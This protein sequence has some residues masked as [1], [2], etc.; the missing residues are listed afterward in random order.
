MSRP[1]GKR[2]GLT[3]ITPQDAAFINVALQSDSPVT[4]KQALQH[5]CSLYRQGGRL[6]APRNMK[7][8]IIN[9]LV[10]RDEKVKRWAFNA[11]AQLGDEADVDLIIGPWK[12]NQS[13]RAVF[14]AGLTALSTLLPKEQLLTVLK[15][16]G[17][18]LDAS[19]LMALGQQSDQFRAELAQVRLDVDSADDDEL[20]AATLLIGLKKAPQ[21]L[22]S[23]R[24]PVSDVIGDLNTHDDPTV[25][26]YSFWATVEHPDLGFDSVRVPPHA[27]PQLP[28][29]VQSWAYRTLTKSGAQAVTH[30]EAIIIGS[31]S[32][33]AEV[34]EGVAIGLRH[35]YYDS[36]DQTVYDW[37]LEE[38]QPAV[39]HRLLEHMAGHSAKSPAYYEEVIKAFRAEAPGSVL[40]SRLEAAN[41]DPLMSLEMRKITLQMCD[42]DLFAS[43]VGNTMNTQNF[44]GPVTAAGI[45]NSGPGNTGAVQIMTTNEARAKVM[46]VLQELQQGLEATDAPLA[47]AVGAA[48]TKDAIEAPTKGKLATLVG[49]L[50][51]I[52]DG[53]EAASKIGGLAIKSYEKLLPMLDHVPD[54]F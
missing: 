30:Y 28:E 50:K 43:L 15:V 6:A 12:A 9:A 19:T 33:S 18:D 34:R 26:Q 29:N 39:V 27:F 4:R 17:V 11:M 54:V 23:G 37:L 13:N 7:G 48:M 40:R 31:E 36:L 20:R 2:R 53:G 8:L 41:R 3:R 49:W 42:P 51:T 10:D 32:L 22:F 46:P 47:A 38:R 24:H 21:T 52:K 25:A 14:E 44:N 45:S 35:I 5:L 16:T 1:G